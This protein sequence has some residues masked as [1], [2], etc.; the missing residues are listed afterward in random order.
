MNLNEDLATAEQDLE[1][2]YD[3][4]TRAVEREGNMSGY[5]EDRLDEMYRGVQEELENYEEN[6]RQVAGAVQQGDFEDVEVMERVTEAGQSLANAYHEAKVLYNKGESAMNH[7]DEAFDSNVTMTSID[8]I[9]DE[10]GMINNAV[11]LKEDA[12]Q[13]YDEALQNVT[14]EAVDAYM[15]EGMVANVDVGLGQQVPEQLR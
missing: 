6:L 4:M 7:G 9:S 15:E 10:I 5:V 2:S 13:N 11:D 3:M 14:S 1:L 8:D 12:F